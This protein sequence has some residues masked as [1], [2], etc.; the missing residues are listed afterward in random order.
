MKSAC[1]KCVAH[2]WRPRPEFARRA[3]ETRDPR[4]FHQGVYAVQGEDRWIAIV[5]PGAADWQTLRRFANI[6]DVADAPARD[7]AIEAWSRNLDGKI[8]M[9]ELQ[10][11]GIAAGV[12][13]DIEDLVQFDPQLAARGSLMMLPHPLLGSFGHMRTP[14]TLHGRVLRPYRAPNIGEHSL[15]IAREICGLAPARIAELESKEVF[16]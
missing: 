16:Q 10:R 12:V 6:A 8:L 1:S 7:A 13:Q 3:T 2:S 14:I 11:A 9:D 15:T 5:L 4:L